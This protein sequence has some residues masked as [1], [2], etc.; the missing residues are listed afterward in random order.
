MKNKCFGI[1]S[2]SFQKSK[3]SPSALQK[4]LRSTIVL[5]IQVSYSI[6]FLEGSCY[7]Q[8]GVPG[9]IV[10]IPGG[11]LCLGVVFQI[12]SFGIDDC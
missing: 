10:V 6:F 8:L 1:M 3:R 12:F 7:L 9:L 2:F 4:I 5:F 11:I